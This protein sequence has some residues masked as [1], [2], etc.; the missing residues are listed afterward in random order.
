VHVSRLC[1]TNNI[2]K[3]ISTASTTTCNAFFMVVTNGLTTRSK[4]YVGPNAYLYYW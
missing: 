4:V 1:T 2:S 3:K